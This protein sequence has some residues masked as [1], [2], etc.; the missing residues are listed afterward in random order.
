MLTN[1]AKL[2]KFATDENQLSLFNQLNYNEKE[3]LRIIVGAVGAACHGLRTGC[4][5]F[6]NI[7][8]EDRVA[9][10]ANDTNGDGVV[11]VSDAVSLINYL[12]QAR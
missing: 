7:V 12:L 9:P 2:T 3:I 10:D 1:N 6:A 4:D 8:A 11:N 5:Q